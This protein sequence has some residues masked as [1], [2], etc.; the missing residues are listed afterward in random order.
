M[1]RARD[2]AVESR[3]RRAAVAGEPETPA[4]GRERLARALQRLHAGLSHARAKRAIT[5]GQVQV[6]GRT[7][8][9]P[10]AWVEAGSEVRWRRDQP[11]DRTP[12]HL[13]IELLHADADIAVAVKPAGLLTIPTP[14]REKDTLV[15]RLASAITRKRGERP[16][17]SVV[18]RLD[19]DTSGLCAFATS[20]RGLVS[21]QAQLLDRS[22]SR[23]YDAVVVGDLAVAAGSFDQELVGDGMR[24][25]RWVARPGER[26]KTAVTHWRVVERF[27]VATLV[28]VSLETGR[29]HQ[30]RIHF[31]AAGHPVVGDAVYSA[32]VT[33]AAA[34]GLARQA[35]HAGE[36]AFRHPADGRALR[37]TA[38]PPD[39]FGRLLAR[40]RAG[41]VRG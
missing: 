27:G 7:E 30:I 39:D 4:G 41:K 31:A 26:G 18:H 35:L 23:V 32:G 28:R 6:A 38:A 22:M 33:K 15:S 12:E 2:T 16:F 34:L 14:D 11:V 17:L 37:F 29:T 1:V 24:R 13:R 25:K 19:R 9:D 5:E 36:L 10:G 20:R 40:L 21:L 8:R 3:A